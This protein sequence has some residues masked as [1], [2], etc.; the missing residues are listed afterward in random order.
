M[1]TCNSLF[2]NLFQT[3]SFSREKTMS[4]TYL[5][6][7]GI[8]VFSLLVVGVVLTGMEYKTIEKEQ[9]DD[10]YTDVGKR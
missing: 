7:L 2:W 1:G 6:F 8:L 10:D 9:T 3:T 5:L 4:D